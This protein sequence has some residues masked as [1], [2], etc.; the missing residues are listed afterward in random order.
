M[1][2]VEK[3]VFENKMEE[4]LQSTKAAHTHAGKLIAFSELMKAVFGVTSF[5]IVQNVEQYVKTGGVMV[6]K[7]RMDLRLGQTI[8]EFKIDL[9]R[10]L[11]TAKEE[12]ERYTT[13]LRN[14][15]QKVA[16][17]II[18]DGVEFKV[19]SVHGKPSEVR[20][21]N[22]EKVAPEQ[23]ILFLDTFLFSK[24]KVPTALDLNMRFGPGSLIYE[25]LISELAGLFKGMKDPVK[26]EL[27]AK[28][29]QLVYGSTPPEDAFVSQT[30]L[31][32]LVRLL[33]AKRLTKGSQFPSRDA[34]NGKLFNSQGICITEDD[35]FSWILNTMFWGQI[36]TLLETIMDALDNYDLDDID[37]DIFKEIY[38]EIVKRADRHKLGEYYTP[39]WLAELTL[40]HAVG[41]I[42]SKGG[43]KSFLAIDPACGSGTFLTN[44]VAMLRKN[45]CSLEEILNN[46]YGIDLNPMAVTI[47]RAN[48]LLALG[49]LI[50]ERKTAIFIPVFMA[51]SIK[52]PETRKEFQHG[53]DVVVIDADKEIKLNLPKDI[54]L[55]DDK[56]KKVLTVFSEILIEY[57]AQKLDSKQAVK[58]FEKLYEGDS[59]AKAIDVLK[60]TL[61]NLILLI[62]A[63]KDS[64]WVFM[65]RNIYAPLRMREKN[66]DL[67]VG[68]PPWISFKYIDNVEYQ[69]FVKKEAFKYKLLE[70]NQTELFTQMD[71]AT[72]FY[73]RTADLYLSEK[74]VLAFVL[75]RSVLTGAKQ[76]EAFKEQQKPQM[77]IIRIIDVEKVNPLFKVPACSIIA[78][79]G[80]PTK[81][82]VDTI[83]A[84][85]ELPERNLRLDKAGKF[86]SFS[87]SSYRTPPKKGKTIS[88]YHSKIV[89]GACIVPRTLWFIKF[90]S[91]AFGVNPDTPSVESL[92]LP[93]AK[94]PWKN[95]ILKG[96]VESEFLF[97][98]TTGK[99]LLPF[100][101]QFLPIV[102]PVKRGELKLSIQTSK[103][104]RRE[105]SLKMANWLE[106]A[107]KQWSGHAT[108]TN[109]RNFPVVTDYVNYHGKLFLQR[110]NLR[111]YVIQTGSGSHI[112]A[113]VVDTKKIPQISSGKAKI[114]PVCFIADYTTFWFATNSLPEAHYL[115]AILNSNVMDKAIKKSQPQGK[116]GPRHICRLPFEQNIPSFDRHNKLHFRIALAGLRASKEVATVKVTSRAKMKEA[117]PSMKRIDALVSNLLQS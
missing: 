63:S 60:H 69:D 80:K 104:L 43:R 47:A 97:L 45:G 61:E 17:C 38:E 83:V 2:P 51:D 93:D 12:I 84:Q 39:E 107:Q 35:F 68:N 82:P 88:P 50:E 112:A 27:W 66:F 4:Y 49:K 115:T 1:P 110:Q 96:E 87:H 100:K 92:V 54:A 77:E 103:D 98:T 21:I 29:M 40:N 114:T 72:V 59:N 94:E 102:L 28:N 64:V 48:Y 75:P 6:L 30:Y 8:L 31:M 55:N 22:F 53:I 62:N 11:E 74:G 7:G 90:A 71:T 10:E 44:M 117:I 20:S 89:E 19:Y 113:A 24:R 3:P 99:N 13:I 108:K 33:L 81:Y 86:L 18:T 65:M 57:K 76:H 105:G 109:L 26:F 36:K 116:W 85:G 58:A 70:S 32:V 67:V 106:E 37:E 73:C 79:K 52:I 101:P 56:L 34:L 111:Y 42:A 9:D 41:E 14:K 95:T 78:R 46:V 23:A 15:G 5:E 16:V 25:E 91:G